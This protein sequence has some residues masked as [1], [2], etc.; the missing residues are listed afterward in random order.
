MAFYLLGPQEAPLSMS[1]SVS[2]WY[3]GDN[4]HTSLDF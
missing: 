4:T 2:S 3:K 1:I